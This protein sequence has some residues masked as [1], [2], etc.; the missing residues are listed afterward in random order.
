MG[1]PYFL[2]RIRRWNNVVIVGSPNI[3][4]FR[5]PEFWVYLLGLS[6]LLSIVLRRVRAQ[7]PPLRDEVH[8]KTVAIEHVQSGVAWVR[9][10]GKVR[11]IN[12]SLATTFAAA[13]RELVGR[14]WYELFVQQDRQK[15]KDAFSQMLLLGKSTMDVYG[16]RID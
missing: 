5:S 14:E 11:S 8:M 13:P 4:T 12:R 10:D 7:Q 16:R 15:L 9:A 6:V 2:L 1:E 3:L